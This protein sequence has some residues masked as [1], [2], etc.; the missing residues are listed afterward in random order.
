MAPNSTTTTSANP[1]PKARKTNVWRHSH[2]LALS[3]LKSRWRRGILWTTYLAVVIIFILALSIAISSSTPTNKPK[4]DDSVACLPDGRFSLD[5]GEFDFWGYG[6]FFEITMGYG[7][8][9]FTQAK[10]IDVGWDVVVG[11]GGQALLALISSSVFARYIT[12]TMQVSPITFNTFKTIFV[13]RD[14][15]TATGVSRLIRDF[16][17]RKSLPNKAATVF[18]VVTMVYVLIFPTFVSSMSGYS[19]N[20]QAFVEDQSERYVPFSDFTQLYY[21]IHDAE[22]IKGDGIKLSNDTRITSLGLDSKLDPTT[23]RAKQ[24]TN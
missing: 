3:D 2:S 9:T 5:P 15:N 14:A 19:A 23:T 22:R 13:A 20:V 11:R 7:Q 1:S 6:G 12:T 18:M 8:F 4:F 17:R 21:T 24:I 16:T 10:A